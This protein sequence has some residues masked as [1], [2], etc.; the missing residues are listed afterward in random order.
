MRTVPP[1]EF[2]SQ[3]ARGC[4]PGTAYA[5][6]EY[7]HARFRCACGAIH[8]LGEDA[9]PVR[10]TPR[11]SGI[12]F[13]AAC[14]QGGITLLKARGVLRFKRLEPQLWTLI[15]TESDNRELVLGTLTS[16]GVC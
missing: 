3:T 1:R 11:R 12:Y 2:G 6:D 4:E 15:E 9:F 7:T 10:D 14:D 5:Y 13:V 16:R 8:R